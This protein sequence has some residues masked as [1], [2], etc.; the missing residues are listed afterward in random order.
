[1]LGLPLAYCV[2]W[3]KALYLSE[4]PFPQPGRQS[5]HPLTTADIHPDLHTSQCSPHEPPRKPSEPSTLHIIS[6][7]QKR[8]LKHRETA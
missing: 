5:I 1:M 3:D 7:F 4:L 2:P 8:T 6:V